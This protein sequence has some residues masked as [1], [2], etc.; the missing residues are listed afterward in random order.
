M[1]YYS[2]THI[3]IILSLITFIKNIMD[4]K[5]KLLKKYIKEA[6]SILIISHLG[7]DPDAFCSMLLLKEAIKQIYPNKVVKIKAKQMPNFNIPTMKDIEV[8]EKLEE[9]EEDLIIVT[10]MTGILSCTENNDPL[11]ETKKRIVVIDHHSSKDDTA[12]LIINEKRS[13][14]AEQVYVSVKEIFGGELEITK[15]MSEITQ[16]G[17]IA[18]THR[19]L[20]SLTT[21]ETLRIYADLREISPVNIETFTYNSEK[22]PLESI[23]Y[24]Q[25]LIKNITI[26]GDMAYTFIDKQPEGKKLAS[27]RRASGFIINNVLRQIQGVHW[28]F[29]VKPSNKENNWELSFRSTSG[30]QTVRKFAEELNGGGHDLASGAGTE[31]KTIEEAIDNVLKVINKLKN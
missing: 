17:I 14:A 12:D 28:G 2:L 1:L 16:Y 7:P 4:E 6:N 31:A 8:V 11:R 18:D 9:G 3:C 30:Y 29:T 27:I 23:Q 21:P 26:I 5:H 22:F 15:D 13:S 19:F 25:I 10:D 20:Y 24:L